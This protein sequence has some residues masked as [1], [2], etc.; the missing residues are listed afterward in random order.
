VKNR[1]I[2]SVV[3]SAVAGLF[4][5]S[6]ALAGE[7]AAKGEGN[8]AKGEKKGGSFC[9]NNS[10]HGNSACKGHGN[11]SCK[12]KNTC[13]GKGFLAAKTKEECEKDGKGVWKEG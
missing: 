3:A 11:A 9:Q 8:Q 5:S 6:V 1:V 2:G 10:C 12:G 7:G 13:A 4:A